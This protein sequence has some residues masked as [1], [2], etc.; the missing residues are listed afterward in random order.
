VQEGVVEY[1][2]EYV[3]SSARNYAGKRGLV[4]IVLVW[5]LDEVWVA[6]TKFLGESCL[7]L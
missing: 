4:E 3:Y 6:E 1:P 2:E 7:S 5:V